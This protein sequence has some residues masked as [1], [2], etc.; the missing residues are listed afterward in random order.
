[1]S[2]F[3]IKTVT[4]ASGAALSEEL[5]LYAEATDNKGLS[6][7]G[8]EMPAAWTAAGIG[9]Q[10]A[11]ASGGTFKAAKRASDLSLIEIS[12]GTVGEMYFFNPQ[13]TIGFMYVKVWS[14]TSGSG[15]N[16]GDDRSIN[17]ICRDFS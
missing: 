8:V 17:L 11:T 4:I 1:M 12:A 7:V 9:F 16:Q 15:V 6:I 14:Q 2:R 10:I 13:D 3:I 5:D